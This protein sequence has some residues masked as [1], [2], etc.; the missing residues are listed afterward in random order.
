ML[1]T[2]DILSE[3]DQLPHLPDNIDELYEEWVSI[4]GTLE[5]RIM[6]EY[7]GSQPFVVK[8]EFKVTESEGML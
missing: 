6:K 7:P 3:K 1:L 4:V 8:R 5:S 2:G